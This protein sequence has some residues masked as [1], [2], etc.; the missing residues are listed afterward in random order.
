MDKQ[1]EI[2]GL[3]ASQMDRDFQKEGGVKREREDR[4]IKIYMQRKNQKNRKRRKEKR[5]IE[6]DPLLSSK[7]EFYI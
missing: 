6:R 5:K 3:L 2:N 1:I 7:I 4:Q